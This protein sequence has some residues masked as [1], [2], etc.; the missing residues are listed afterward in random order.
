[1]KHACAEA[2]RRLIS[3]GSF[4]Q[5]AAI[6]PTFRDVLVQEG[7]E[8]LAAVRLDQATVDEV[9][10]LVVQVGEADPARGRGGVGDPG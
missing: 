10:E 2:S 5:A 4:P 1:M 6:L 7:L 9:L 8:A 3:T